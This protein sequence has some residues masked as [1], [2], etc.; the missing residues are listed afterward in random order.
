[1]T[2][3][4]LG[5]AACSRC[6]VYRG[7]WQASGYPSPLCGTCLAVWARR[8]YGSDREWLNGAFGTTPR[9]SIMRLRRGRA[10]NE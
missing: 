9:N 2:Y 1:M 4:Y 5:N 10:G 3:E 7:S 8:L 6:G